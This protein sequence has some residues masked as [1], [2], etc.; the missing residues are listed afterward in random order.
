MKYISSPHNALIRYAEQLQRKSKTRKKEGQF[1]IEGQREIQLARAGNFEMTQVLVCSEILLGRE[2][3]EPAQV[4][5]QLTLEENT[6]IIAVSSEV[7]EKLAYRSGTEGCIAFAKAKNPHLS[8]LHLSNA[9]LILIAESPEKPGNIGAL[10]RTADA[11]NID[12]VIIVD[13][14]SDLYNPNV[15]R[16]SVGCVF[17]VPTAIASA[18]DTI[19]FLKSNDINL[20]AATLQSSENYDRM[21]FTTATA[22]A[23]GT[24]AT[25]LSKHLR[26]AAKTNIIIPMGGAIDS[27]NVSVSAAVLLFEAKRQRGFG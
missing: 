27:M 14:V 1:L 4:R 5:K 22:I 2:D 7:Y 9:P 20:Y 12:A 13:P 6:D 10:L 25:G 15:I 24:E 17:T 21:D 8:Q 11:A 3:F 16:S 23:V 18:A 26:D 19:A